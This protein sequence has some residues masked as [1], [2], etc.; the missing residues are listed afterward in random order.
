VAPTREHA[1]TWVYD[2]PLFERTEDGTGWMFAHHPFTA[3]F[4]EDVPLLR[5][6]ELNGIRAQH[7]DA[8][9]NGTELGSG[10]IRI[11]DPELQML[12]FE[13]IGMPREQIVHRFGFLLQA[14]RGGAPPHGGMALGFDRIVMLL[15]GADS[16]RDVIAFP[17]T[18]AAR[19]LYEDAPTTVPNDELADLGIRMLP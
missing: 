3:P 14:L 2:F 19:A 11:G 6:G 12:A 1:F 7:Y 5:T 4:T 9:Y 10:S 15:A 18:T 16:L 13:A 17:K 8:V